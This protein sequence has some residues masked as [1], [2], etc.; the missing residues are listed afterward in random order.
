MIALSFGCGGWVGSIVSY[1]LHLLILCSG[2]ADDD[3][4]DVVLESGP[5]PLLK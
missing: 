2:Y 5:F 4:T 1:A 3:D